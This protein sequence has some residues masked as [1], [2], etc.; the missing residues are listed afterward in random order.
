MF[1]YFKPFCVVIFVW[2]PAVACLIRSGDRLTRSLFLIAS[3][4]KE[5]VVLVFMQF[6][7]EHILSTLAEECG[8]NVILNMITKKIN[9]TLS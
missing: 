3:A 1:L 9:H 2:L 4:F 7:Y 5:F 8:K 6:I